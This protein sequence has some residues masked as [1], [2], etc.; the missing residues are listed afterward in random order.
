MLIISK[1]GQ[2]LME[3][4]IAIA[5]GVIMIGVAIAVIAPALKIRS[6]TNEAKIGAALGRELLENFRVV[7]ESNWHNVDTLATGTNNTFYF[8]TTTNLFVSTSGQELIVVGT[9]TYTRYFYIED[10]CRS[11]IDYVSGV[12][13][14]NVGD[15]NDPSTKK[16]TVIFRWP[17]SETSTFSTYVTRF[18]NQIFSQSDWSGGPDLWGP[19]TGTVSGFATSS[20]INFSSTT[21]SIKI[22][23][24]ESQ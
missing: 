3:I 20:N 12:A 2:S 10:V 23:D 17:D 1:K 21:G 13:P 7:A 6:E 11:A 15:K 4:L 8:T 16:V 19:V 14:C 9:T 24:V 18:K 5:I 22:L